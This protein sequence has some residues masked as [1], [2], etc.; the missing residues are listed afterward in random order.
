MSKTY[1]LID[2]FHDYALRFISVIA[3]RH[4]YRPLCLTTERAG[5]SGLRAYPALRDCERLHV[6]GDDLESFGKK[7]VSEREVL[8]AVPFAESVLKPVVSILRGMGSTWNDP[9]MLAL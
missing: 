6:P 8:G 5:A 7:L 1:V 9:A 4:G 3:E 2:P